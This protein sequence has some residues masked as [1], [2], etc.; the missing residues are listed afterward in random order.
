MKNIAGNATSILL[1]LFSIFLFT[2]TVDPY[3][4]EASDA[5]ATFTVQ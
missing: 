4:A 5:K 1:A 3:S 2:I